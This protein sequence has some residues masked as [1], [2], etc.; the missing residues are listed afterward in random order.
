MMVINE[1]CAIRLRLRWPTGPNPARQSLHFCLV[2]S[3]LRTES[4]LHERVHAPAQPRRMWRTRP[5][6]PRSGTTHPFVL[7]TSWSSLSTEAL[8]HSYAAEK[9]RAFWSP[10][11]LSVH[12]T[13]LGL[14]QDRN[15]R[16]IFTPGSVWELPP[17]GR[18][19]ASRA[20]RLL[21]R[22]LQHSGRHFT[23][24]WGCFVAANFLRGLSC[25]VVHLL[26]RRSHEAEEERCKKGGWGEKGGGRPRRSDPEP[27]FPRRN[28]LPDLAAPP[29]GVGQ[30][31]TS[32]PLP[33]CFT[34]SAFKTNLSSL[35]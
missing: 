14:L 1:L 19:G 34:H 7:T 15:R 17:G 29:A 11:C 31:V 32:S 20:R 8:P 5:L 4:L 33:S 18:G 10:S 28:L 24:G 2:S 22:A 21:G 13:A 9:A 26:R 12:P 23:T 30:L 35:S 3:R 16:A 25:I 6:R 27:H